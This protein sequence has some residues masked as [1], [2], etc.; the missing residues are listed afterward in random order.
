MVC[1]CAS[2]EAKEQ[3]PAVKYDAEME[4]YEMSYDEEKNVDDGLSGSSGLISCYQIVSS[5]VLESELFVQFKYFLASS[6]Q[7]TL[8]TNKN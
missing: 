5:F 1:E 6:H 4:C 7:L 2:I 8:T 3:K